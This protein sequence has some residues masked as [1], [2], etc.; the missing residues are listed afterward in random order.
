MRGYLKLFAVLCV[1]AAC[2]AILRT[3]DARNM[4]LS[5]KLTWAEAYG[6]PAD[7]Q[8]ALEEFDAAYAAASG[9]L[10]LVEVRQRWRR[11]TER[12][13]AAG[14]SRDEAVGLAATEVDGMADGARDDPG[15][16]CTGGDG[17]PVRGADGTNT[18]A[19]PAPGEGPDD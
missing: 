11:A 4:W 1:V 15:N 3:D 5:Q 2:F 6:S 12:L 17:E 10:H 19:A 14:M 16:G 7:V 13:V 18:C 9:N 8:R